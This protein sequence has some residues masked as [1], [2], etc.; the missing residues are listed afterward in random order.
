MLDTDKVSNPIT[1]YAKSLIHGRQLLLQVNKQNNVHVC[2]IKDSKRTSPFQTVHQ[3]LTLYLYPKS[4]Q[5]QISPCNING[6]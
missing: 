3:L 1:L 5:H 2:C 4:D 6:L